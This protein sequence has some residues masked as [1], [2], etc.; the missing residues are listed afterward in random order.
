LEI[1]FEHSGVNVYWPCGAGNVRR[2]R[3]NLLISK[4]PSLAS[5]PHT[6]EIQQQKPTST[7]SRSTTA[8]VV[9]ELNG[10]F[11]L[12]EVYLSEIQPDE[13]LVEIHASGLCHTDLSFATGVLPCQPGAVLGHEGLYPFACFTSTILTP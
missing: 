2:L 5:P 11:E 4:H 6:L 9:P 12:R 10:K 7:R 13:V 8:L 1:L 3:L